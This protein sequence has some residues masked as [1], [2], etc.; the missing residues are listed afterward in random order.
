MLSVW[1]RFWIIHFGLKALK[2]LLIQNLCRSNLGVDNGYSFMGRSNL[3][4]DYGYSG[5]KILNCTLQIYKIFLRKKRI[6]CMMLFFKLQ[7]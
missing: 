4:M 6:L 5:V 1:T 3:G 2:K 7:Q